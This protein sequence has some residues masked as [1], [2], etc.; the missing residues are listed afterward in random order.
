MGGKILQNKKFNK[1]ANTFVEIILD[2]KAVEKV[3]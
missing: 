1:P 3:T 2:T